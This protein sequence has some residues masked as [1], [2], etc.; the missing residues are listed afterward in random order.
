M[1]IPQVQFLVM[2][3]TCPSLCNDIVFVDRKWWTLPVCCRDRY[4][5][6]QTV[7]LDWLLTCPLLCMSRSLTSLSWR[8]GHFPWSSSADH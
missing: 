3:M 6:C 7:H 2:L 1:E 5:Q 4:A 8:R